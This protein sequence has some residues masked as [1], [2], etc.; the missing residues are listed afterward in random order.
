[1]ID[2]HTRHLI[3]V[4]QA[5]FHITAFRIL[6]SGSCYCW[7]PAEWLME[8]FILPPW[9]HHKCCSIIQPS[10][11]LQV[12]CLL[13]DNQVT[14]DYTLILSP[15]QIKYSHRNQETLG[16]LNGRESST[17]LPESLTGNDYCT[18]THCWL[19]IHL[20]KN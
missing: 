20:N 18:S 15:A 9:D 19:L 16:R 12:Q 5:P 11:E 14:W 10:S 2:L 7:R 13:G 1:M 4:T 8:P 3:T 6:Q 17:S